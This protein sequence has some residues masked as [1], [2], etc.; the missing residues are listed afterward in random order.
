MDEINKAV[1][2]ARKRVMWNHFFRIIAWTLLA[3][4]LLIE[5]GPSEAQ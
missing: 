2:A 5:V 1:K 3:T 4:L